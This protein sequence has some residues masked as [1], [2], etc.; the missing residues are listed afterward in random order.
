MGLALGALLGFPAGHWLAA[1]AT[2]AADRRLPLVLCLVFL[3]LAMVPAQPE[4][5]GVSRFGFHGWFPLLGLAAAF[6]MGVTWGCSLPLLDLDPE[7][8]RRSNLIFIGAGLG[9]G[10]L[11]A[12]GAALALSSFKGALLV[13]LFAAPLVWPA[14]PSRGD[15]SLL[16]RMTLTLVVTLS[17]MFLLFV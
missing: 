17:A 13:N 14:L 6:P 7:V 1:R 16:A 2:Q 5:V 4:I 11:I 10:V 9:L 8:D 15:R 3:P 12:A